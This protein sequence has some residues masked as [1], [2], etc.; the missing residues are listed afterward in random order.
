MHTLGWPEIVTVG[1]CTKLTLFT[2]VPLHP[3]A[4]VPK[5]VYEVTGAKGK[6]VITELVEPLLHINEEAP[7]AESVIAAPLQTVE[8]PLIEIVGAAKICTVE[9][10]GAFV[11]QPQIAPVYMTV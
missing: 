9:L 4:S 6:S 5:A 1:V 8:L 2:A 11:K 3:F 7:L 10:T